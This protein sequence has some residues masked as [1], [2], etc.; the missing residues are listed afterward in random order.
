MAA[1]FYGILYLIKKTKKTNSDDDTYLKVLAR[2]ALNT[3]S[4]AAVISVGRQAWL[5]GITNS[6]VNL[7]SEITDQVTIDSM[8]LAYRTD[9]TTAAAPLTFKKL[10]EKFAVISEKAIMKSANK[11]AKTA[12]SFGGNEINGIYNNNVAPRDTALPSA[13]DD[14][15]ARLREKRNELQGL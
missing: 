1:A 4:S 6:S 7:I 11:A 13:D 8:E 2:T 14:A 5:V 10:L 12:P 9:T 15:A 3:S